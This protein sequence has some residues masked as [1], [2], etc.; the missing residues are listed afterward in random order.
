MD[1]TSTIQKATELLF[2]L[3]GQNAPCGVSAIA[4]ALSAPKTNV[5]RLLQSLRH[6]NLVEQDERGRYQLGVGLVAL[7]LGASGREPLL[8]A[9]RPIMSAAVR[10]LGETLF[11]VSARAGELLVL[12]KVEGSGFL[13]VS[14]QVGSTVPAHATAV[15]RLYLAF[16]PELLTLRPHKRFTD[17]TPTDEADLNQLIELA[18]ARGVSESHGEWQE[19]LSAIAAPILVGQR[20]LGALVAAVITPRLRE[21][22]AERVTQSVRSATTKLVKRLEGAKP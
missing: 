10:E 4:R 18:R 15:G 13:R 22:G 19:G 3:N 7:G 12:D 11:L 20:M 17:K 5:H 9:A 16:A 14:P 2:F 21:L 1:T 6:R 8:H